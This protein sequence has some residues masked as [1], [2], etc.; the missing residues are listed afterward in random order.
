LAATIKQK[1]KC[2]V[3]LVPGGNGVFEVSADGKLLFSK[4]Q[5]VRFPNGDEIVKALSTLRQRPG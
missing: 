4:R 2:P 5:S 1:F 3:E